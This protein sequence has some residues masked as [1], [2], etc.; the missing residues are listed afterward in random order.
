MKVK[1]LSQLFVIC[2]LFN[3]TTV[4]AEP[5]DAS[6][7]ISIK[8][9]DQF[10]ELAENCRIDSYSKDLT[11]ELECDIDLTGLHF[12]PI[13][14]FNGTFKGNG[15][16]ITGLSI[17]FSGSTCGLFRY[18]TE[19][20]IIQDLKVSGSVTPAGSGDY[21]GG[22]AGE[23][24]G[25]IQNCSF[26]GTINGTQYIG[27]IAGMNRGAIQN[28]S[29]DGNIFGKHFVGGIVGAN[30]GFIE[31]CVNNGM[32]N[33]DPYHSQIELSDISIN[34]LTNT[35]SS[36]TVTDI[37]GI[38]GT[39]TSMIHKCDNYGAIGYQHIGYNIGGICGTGNG[40]ITACN[41]YG[42]ISGRKEVGGIIG[43]LEPSLNL[44]YN[45]DSIQ[46]LQSQ[47]KQLGS[48]ISRISQTIMISVKDTGEQ[49]SIIR[50]LVN[51]L[52][53]LISKTDPQDPNA[54]TSTF[55][56]IKIILRSVS[57]ILQDLFQ[58]ADSL[59]ETLTA[60][61]EKAGA[62]VQN[63]QNT[64]NAASDNVGST[65]AD[66]SLFDTEED[67]A[68]ELA[69]CNNFGVVLG[70]LTCGGVVGAVSF[71]ND[72]DPEDDITFSGDS[73]LNISGEFRA[74]IRECINVSSV[75]IG[76]QYAGGIVGFLSLGLIENCTNSG[77]LQT[78]SAAYIG[79]IA[80]YCKGAIRSCNSKCRI[81]ASKYAGGIA[82]FGDNI[83][84]CNALCEVTALEKAGAIAG[85]A[86]STSL[87][88]KNYYS[89]VNDD[90]GGIDGINYSGCAE[91]LSM[92][93]FLKLEN[94]P[95]LFSESKAIFYFD[96]GS[97]KQISLFPGE[98]LTDSNIPATNNI[99]IFAYWSGID[100]PIY[101]DTDFYITYESFDTVFESTQKRE[102]GLSVLLAEC[103][104]S[105][106]NPLIVSFEVQNLPVNA[107]DAFSLSPAS[108]TELRYLPPLHYRADQIRICYLAQNGQWVTIE[109]TVHGSY[110]RFDPREA[111]TFCVLP[112]EKQPV[113]FLL[114]IIVISLA[115]ATSIV[116]LVIK[117]RK[118]THS[119][120]QAPK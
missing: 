103:P 91:P 96:D 56:E 10:M 55:E 94:L 116:L 108:F 101:F 14:I 82:G 98:I 75:T 37:G 30:Y 61:L 53:D 50:N 93:D 79:G 112:Q 68:S 18:L 86:Q 78:P 114:A 100:R 2:F 22:I 65:F 89:P 8:T 38:A 19:N 33:T 92:Q 83:T 34:S 120:F 62:T 48:I 12:Q 4:Y 111:T 31:T 88:I 52:E 47:V 72:L 46:I 60:D 107:I 21:A 85:F 109:H 6:Q 64:L 41:N 25:T 59:S 118:Q 80:G 26:S 113:I 90:I 11:V 87:P 40:Y 28:C 27:G 17:Q 43:Q 76:K 77:H 36:I 104:P 3:F 16:S 115:A 74:V 23:N 7:F 29:F 49:I 117:K 58:R 102:N 24:A 99:G 70:D 84:E 15:H 39:N 35:E 5:E 13:A 42:S 106:S 71:E 9:T 110:A 57:D 69:Q 66:V 73:S 95:T 81:E 97:V 1:I 119:K 63:M 45:T 44:V 32:V 54:I 20:A 67:T 51:D 105:Q